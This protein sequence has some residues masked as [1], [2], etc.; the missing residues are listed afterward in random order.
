MSI[1]KLMDQYDWVVL[2]D[3]P[4]AL[5]S[6]GMAAKLGLS[7]LMVPA[8]S[9]IKKQIIGNYFCFDPEK[10]FLLGLRSGDQRPGLLGEI[11]NKIG[12]SE[13]EKAMFF[14]REGTPQV[15]SR[16]HRVS[17]F[18]NADTFRFELTREFGAESIKQLGLM[19]AL[20][21]GQAEI[22]KFWFHFP[23]Q[24]VLQREDQKKSNSFLSYSDLLSQLSRKKVPHSDIWFSKNKAVS[25]I[26][27]VL[28]SESIQNWISGLWYALM[29][30]EKTDPIASEFIQALAFL[31]TA[32]S[33][34]GGMGA[35]RAILI[36]IAKR[37]GAHVLES[38]EC[39][40]I[41]VNGHQ[42]TGIQLSHHGSVIGARGMALGCILDEA[43]ERM[44]WN[45]KKSEYSCS[46]KR[47]AP[48]GWKF[49]IALRVHAEA[50]SPGLMN[51]AVWQETGAPSL[52]IEVANPK[53]YNIGGDDSRLIFLRT[54]LPY[55]EKYLQTS[56]L[57]LIA[58]RMLRQLMEILPFLEYHV[59]QIYPDFR[60]VHQLST[61]EEDMTELEKLYYF[62]KL[63]EIPSNL[64]CYADTGLPSKT[65]IEGVFLVNQQTRPELGSLGGVLSAVESVAWIAH[66]SGLSGPLL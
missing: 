31:Q 32:G 3:H 34:R 8:F 57:R 46:G 14:F 42:I 47:T 65:H 63:S 29:Q 39:K 64:L 27:K 12:I 9:G 22:L 61:S 30:T 48:C 37:N 62:K 25:K 33:V 38:Q 6:A 55:E 17:S 59:I 24:F 35:Y 19:E 53:D 26:K 10:N 60:R 52:E 20:T 28:D 49:T 51:Q 1:S 23:K 44:T 40:R 18:E 50:I 13:S 41:F 54:Q 43:I 56:T 36:Q 2:G 66:K 58:T 15:I 4:A 45:G 16:D 21:V 11:L 7:V 5:L